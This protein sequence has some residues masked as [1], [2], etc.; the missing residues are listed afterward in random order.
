MKCLLAKFLK[1]VLII[2][3]FAIISSQTSAKD[4]N[5]QTLDLTKEIED[6]NSPKNE[7]HTWWVASGEID[8]VAYTKYLFE[9][10]AEKDSLGNGWKPAQVP[11]NPI[12]EKLVSVDVESIWYLKVFYV[13]EI[14]AEDQILYLKRISD[15]DETYLNGILIG[16]M[17]D[18]N[19]DKAQGYDK[20][21]LYKIPKES[22]NIN[23]PNVLLV[24]VRKYFRDSVGI[25]GENVFLGGSQSILRDYYISILKPMF[26]LIC[27]FTV[28]AY[29]VF[30]FLRRRKERE[31]FFF[32]FFA[33][34]FVCYQLLRSQWRFEFPY[35]YYSF[36]KTE[37]AILILLLPS[38]YLFFRYYFI[39]KEKRF[40]TYLHYFNLLCIIPQ[41]LFFCFI[42]FTSKIDLWND[43]LNQ[44]LIAFLWPPLL[45]SIFVIIIYNAFFLKDIDAKI[46]FAGWLIL[47]SGILND[48]LIHL[49]IIRFER[50]TEYSFFI[51]IL[52][53]AFILSNRFVRVHLEVE[54]LNLNLEKKVIHR[55]EELQTAL[56][57]VNELKLSQ[58][59]D[60]FLTYLLLEPLCVKAVTNP[61]IKVEFLISQKK[62]FVFNKNNHEIGGDTCIAHTVS[63]RQRPVTIFLNADAMGKSMQG[64]GGVLVLNSI[65]ES[66][67]KRTMMVGSFAEQS[68][69]SWLVNAFIELHNVFLMFEG[70]MMISLNMGIIDDITGEVIYINAEHPPIVLFRDE[71]ASFLPLPE[72]NCKLGSPL[73]EE[74]I[75]TNSFYLEDKDV[76]LLGS[77]GRDDVLLPDGD[78]NDDYDLFLVYVKNAKTDLKNIYKEILKSGELYDDLSLLRIEFTQGEWN[79]KV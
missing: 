62:K 42:L 73:M 51:F 31:N 29:F 36:K 22:F 20:S 66:I 71:K 23:A 14:P 54:D 27:Y 64:A 52:S 67:V 13:K 55:T 2:L 30:L 47:I 15:R 74:K 18:W 11:G 34:S 26:F 60:Y 19:S 1:N 77:D 48:I 49:E 25:W 5:F 21:R 65:F 69:D 39:K 53:L 79:E 10:K 12:G 61:N 63:L 37:Y 59:G 28:G 43:I 68:P 24:R 35:S 45:I 56:T 58:D 78:I 4:F 40:L 16:K 17:G 76:L 50:I 46:M 9:N 6:L 41:A 33:I 8:P 72:I 38:L 32:G 75:Y 3:F 57:K 70:S 7:E 44:V